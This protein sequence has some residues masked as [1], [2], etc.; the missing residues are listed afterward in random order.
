MSDDSLLADSVRKFCRFIFRSIVPLEGGA[1]CDSEH[2]F[3]Q[4][5]LMH[6]HG[7]HKFS[8]RP[9]PTFPTETVPSKA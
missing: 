7:R 5:H 1:L 2:Y 8:H 4:I 6:P 9:L 3:G